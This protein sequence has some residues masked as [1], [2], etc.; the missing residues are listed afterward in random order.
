MLAKA[1]VV[2]PDLTR[3][4]PPAITASTGLD[5]LTQL[6]EPFVSNRANP[7]TDMICR[8]GLP[9]V[10]QSLERAFLHGGDATAR[11]SMSYASL[12]SGLALANAGLGVVHGF[13][14]PLGG[15][16]QAPHGALC[17]AVLPHGMAINIDALQRREHA[18]AALPK[19]REIAR[20]VTG[21]ANA[22]IEDGVIWVSQ[23]CKRLSVPPLRTYGLAEGQIRSLV[24]KAAQA[25]S[26]KANPIRLTP[27]ELTE[28]A[29]RA[30]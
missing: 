28:I 30:L 17:A 21:S 29:N 14:A 9:H 8:E 5:T 12:L 11:M 1:A 7:F 16:L 2:D 22:S 25:S 15:M 27:P 18:S 13:A 24:E 10:A 20:I 4:L 3:P 19:Y 26:M 6:I 23:L